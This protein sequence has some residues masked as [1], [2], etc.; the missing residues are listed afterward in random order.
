M[1]KELYPSLNKEH[2]DGLKPAL[3]KAIVEIPDSVK[4][5]IEIIVEELLNFKQSVYNDWQDSVLNCLD[6]HYSNDELKI[7]EA[8]TNAS[9][10]LVSHLLLNK[11]EDVLAFEDSILNSFK[12]VFNTDKPDPLYI[13]DENPTSERM[14]PEFLMF[15]DMF[16]RN[17]LS[18]VNIVKTND[19]LLSKQAY[20]YNRDTDFY[21]EKSPLLL[22]AFNSGVLKLS[23]SPIT[24]ERLASKKNDLISQDLSDFPNLKS[25]MLKSVPFSTE[26]WG[27]R[28]KYFFKPQ[29]MFGGKG[30]Y[31][32][33]SLSK[34][35]FD[36]LGSEYM[37][38]ESHP[39][40]KI[41]IDGVEWKY[42]IRAFFSE[43]KVQKIVARVY[44]GQLTNFSTLGGGFALIEW[45]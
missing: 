2:I 7:I 16:E 29:E 38:Q 28:K 12:T 1:I 27:E 10:Y 5:A 13:I 6:F 42:D 34:K 45:V 25:S 8:N 26:L 20:V 4:G 14:Y 17:G 33:K 23:T 11:K 3:S 18:N 39:P 37:A 9:G 30:V 41:Q 36:S 35:K 44:Q 22:E 15:K 32:G 24:Y 43:S 40:G 31:S 19:L 21:F